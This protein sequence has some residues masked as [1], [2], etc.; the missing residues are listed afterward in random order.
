MSCF[1]FTKKAAPESVMP[2][3]ASMA[4]GGGGL[5][6]NDDLMA[7]GAPRSRVQCA[8]STRLNSAM[9][10]PNRDSTAQRARPVARS[11]GW[12]RR[13]GSGGNQHHA[14]MAQSCKEHSVNVKND[15]ADIS[16]VRAVGVKPKQWV[17]KLHQAGVVLQLEGAVRSSMVRLNMMLI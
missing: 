9:P 4:G 14:T 6:S 15:S 11:E 8:Q 12:T 13:V 1:A 10:P 17:C 2:W 7:Q 3:A 16:A 5:P